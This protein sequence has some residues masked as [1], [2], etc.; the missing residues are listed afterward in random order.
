MTWAPKEPPGI[1]ERPITLVTNR[2]RW[3]IGLVPVILGGIFLITLALL[4]AQLALLVLPM[5]VSVAGARS[6]YYEVRLDG[7][8]GEFLG[9]KAPV[10]ISEM[11]RSKA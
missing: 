7:S 11:R 4:H 8:L 10:G 3:V 6:G 5:V 1:Q 2:R 9:R